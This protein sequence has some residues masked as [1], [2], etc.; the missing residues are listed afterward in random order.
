MILFFNHPVRL[1]DGIRILDKD[2]DWT[3]EVK[4]ITGFYLFM[5]TDDGRNITFP[6]SLIIQKGTEI[7]SKPSIEGKGNN[8]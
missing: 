6:T 8:D 5:K 2:F 1:G 3:G 7:M 4:D